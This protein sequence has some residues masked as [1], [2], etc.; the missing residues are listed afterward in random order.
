M[1]VDFRKKHEIVDMDTGAKVPHK[2]VFFA[3]DEA[4]VYRYYASDKEGLP[5]LD[6]L[7][8]WVTREVK[9]R[10]KIVCI[11]PKEARYHHIS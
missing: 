7:D 10:I 1:I 2:H 3:D 6:C 5:Y 9:A 8:R 11:E 4:G